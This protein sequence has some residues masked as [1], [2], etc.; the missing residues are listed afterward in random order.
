MD[1][2]EGAHMAR[3]TLPLKV[4]I[5]PVERECQGCVIIGTALCSLCASLVEDETGIRYIS[6]RAMDG[7]RWRAVQIA[8]L[9]GA[10][11]VLQRQE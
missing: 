10:P 1:A 11:K 6:L 3:D 8:D 7:D 5:K 4:K 2:L 9:S